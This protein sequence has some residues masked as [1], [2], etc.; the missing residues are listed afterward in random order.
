MRQPWL[1]DTTV[2][3]T[4]DDFSPRSPTLPLRKV[5]LGLALAML[6]LAM[7]RSRQIVDALYGLPVLPGTEALIAVAEAWH[8]AMQAIGAAQ[9]MEWLAAL[10]RV[11]G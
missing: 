7:G 6:L 3:T 11:S 2:G 1:Q 8:D 9:A 4:P 10:L 5:A